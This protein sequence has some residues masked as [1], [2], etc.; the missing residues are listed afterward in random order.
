MYKSE[1]ILINYESTGLSNASHPN[2]AISIPILRR[3]ISQIWYV[4]WD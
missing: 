3:H 4:D 2:K 1:Y